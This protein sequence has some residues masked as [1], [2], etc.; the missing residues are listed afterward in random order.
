MLSEAQPP[1]RGVSV[2]VQW[3]LFLGWPVE[4]EIRQFFQKND[5]SLKMDCMFAMS[6]CMLLVLVLVIVHT[7]RDGVEATRSICSGTICRLIL[8][9]VCVLHVM[10]AQG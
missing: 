8:V 9:C 3:F 10:C 2:V 5:I 7:K 4:A 1:V 6:Q